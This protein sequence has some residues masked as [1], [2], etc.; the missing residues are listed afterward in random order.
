MRLWS[1]HPEYLDPAGLVALWREALLAQKV[2]LGQTKGYTRHPQLERFKN[3]CQPREAIA[4]Y[5]KGIWTEANKRGYS[6]DAQ[7]ILPGD[8]SNK[9][10]IT[11]GQLKFEFSWLL[12]KQKIRN[13]NFYEVN[14]K[15][16]YIKAHPLF[17]LK[18]GPIEKWEK[19]K[20]SQ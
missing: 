4:T 18:H 13:F 1:I 19:Q 10:T 16:K 12:E 20:P 6:F 14:K 7:K 8:T 17:V 3:H 2:L 15:V 11:Q 5:L 9:I